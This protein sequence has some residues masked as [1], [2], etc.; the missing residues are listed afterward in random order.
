MLDLFEEE[1][2][3]VARDGNVDPTDLAT[4]EELF[5]FL[6]F[7]KTQIRNMSDEDGQALIRSDYRVNLLV[8]MIFDQYEPTEVDFSYQVSTVLSMSI[9]T[10]FYDLQLSDEQKDKLIEGLLLIGDKQVAGD[11]SFI[12]EV[13][14]LVFCLHLLVTQNN[15]NKVIEA[16]NNLSMLYLMVIGDRIDA[17][18]VSNLLCAWNEVGLLNHSMQAF[19]TLKGLVLEKSDAEAF[20]SSGCG[21]ALVNIIKACKEMG[22]ADD[23][24]IECI[25]EGLHNHFDELD[26]KWLTILLTNMPQLGCADRGILLDHI[27]RFSA[28]MHKFLKKAYETKST[29]QSI[30]DKDASFFESQS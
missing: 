20:F 6:Y 2:I 25:L 17:L 3:S 18:S 27:I 8:Q 13:P 21:T 24:F 29:K 10:K 30:M 9:L 22:I 1:F 28:E 16:V 5:M 23:D 4:I 12:P 14:S 11:G 19:D 15:R 26:I 7:F